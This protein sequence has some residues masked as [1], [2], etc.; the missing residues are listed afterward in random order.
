MPSWDTYSTCC[1]LFKFLWWNIVNSYYP[2]VPDSMAVR[3]W[4]RIHPSDSVENHAEWLVCADIQRSQRGRTPFAQPCVP[5]TH[6]DPQWYPFCLCGSFMQSVD[7]RGG[8][9]PH[10][11]MHTV[12]KNNHLCTLSSEAVLCTECVW[13]LVRIICAMTNYLT[14]S[15]EA[16]ADT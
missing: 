2:G 14:A 11:S 3:G 9:A 1:Y 12:S 13:K 15:C 8:L 7:G 6:F 4:E 16:T 5:P 10:H